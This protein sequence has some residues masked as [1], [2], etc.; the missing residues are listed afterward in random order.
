MEIEDRL[1]FPGLQ[2]EVSGDLAIVL[3]REAVTL[4]PSVVFV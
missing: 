4:L 1:T 2:P 3:V